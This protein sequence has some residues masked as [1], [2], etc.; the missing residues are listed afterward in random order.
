MI[1]Q[2]WPEVGIE[3]EIGTMADKE[4]ETQ[5]TR[6][7]NDMEAE[8]QRH[9]QQMTAHLQHFQEVW[10]GMAGDGGKP[11][12]T[13]YSQRD[14]L[15]ASERLGTSS[16]TIGGYGCL[17]TAIA[18]ALTDAGKPYTPGTLNAWLVLNGGYSGGNNFVFASVDKL[19]VMKY[20]YMIECAT[21][22]A[23]LTQ[24]EAELKAGKFVIVKVDFTPGTVAIDQHWVRYIG[25]GEM[26]D[27]WQ[28]DIAPIVP[29]YRGVDAA[30]AIL[31]CAIY[32][33]VM[34]G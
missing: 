34:Q 10:L 22:P 12:V 13:L 26:L 31:R 18:S 15:W 4:T 23:P 17:I 8:N 16:S 32:R 28:G 7:I 25:N 29:R 2:R 1:R 33:R 21:K 14:P 24:L 30:Q 11:Q 20:E 19:A 9:C 3:T 5:L 27:P 6:I